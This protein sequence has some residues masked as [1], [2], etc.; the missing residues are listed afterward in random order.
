MS[1]KC[2]TASND[3]EFAHGFFTIWSL[4]VN[5][6]VKPTLKPQNILAGKQACSQS[7]IRMLQ[8]DIKFSDT[9]S[10]LRVEAVQT[11]PGY[12]IGSSDWLKYQI[13]ASDWFNFDPD[14][15]GLNGPIRIW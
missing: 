12:R 4:C 9:Y 11:K 14:K 10:Y 6:G 1:T 2:Q 7:P 3:V 13:N 15:A 8:D 5:Y